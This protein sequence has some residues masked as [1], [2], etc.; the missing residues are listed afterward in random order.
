[1]RPIPR[2]ICSSHVLPW[3]FPGGLANQGGS[4]YCLIILLLWIVALELAR[5]EEARASGV[6]GSDLATA[7]LTSARLGRQAILPANAALISDPSTLRERISR[8]LE[9][10]RSKRHGRTQ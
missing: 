3:S 2:A 6:D 4:F 8:L 7:I 10:C 1:M 9:P 5:D